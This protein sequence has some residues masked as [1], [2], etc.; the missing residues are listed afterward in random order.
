MIAFIRVDAMDSVHHEL[1]VSMNCIVLWCTKE[2]A[3]RDQ[4]KADR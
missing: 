2:R 4:S 1:V 3:G